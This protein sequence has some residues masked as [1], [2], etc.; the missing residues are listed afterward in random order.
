MIVNLLIVLLLVVRLIIGVRLIVLARQHRLANIYWLVAQFLAIVI[1]LPFSPVEGNPFGNLPISQW[2][3]NLFAMWGGGHLFLLIF[4]HTT[5]YQDRP[6]PLRWYLG[7]S[8]LA[9]ALTVYG[10]FLSES[11]YHQH[12]LVA[13]LNIVTILAWGWHIW[14]AATAIGHLSATQA[15]E[16]WV[17]TRYQLIIAYSI[18]FLI[19]AGASFLRNTLAGGAA[20]T[21]LGNA[22]AL[23]TLLMQIIGVALQFLV[24]VMPESFRLWLNRDYLPRSH[25]AQ[26]ERGGAILNLLGEAMAVNTGITKLYITLL[27][28]REIGQRL[29]E[30]EDHEKVTSHAATLGYHDWLTILNAE[31]LQKGIANYGLSPTPILD[32]GRQLLLN[33]QSLFTM[34]AK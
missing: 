7:A 13:A 21:P 4:T 22:M 19:G 14:S 3:F 33:N 25:K 8:G 24:W 6:S 5:F 16:D 30:T 12:P 18:V 17:K 20:I 2:V 27:L 15:V 31:S 32:N 28:R 34:Q 23:L 9:L 29:G 11:N 26:I 1:G 10:F